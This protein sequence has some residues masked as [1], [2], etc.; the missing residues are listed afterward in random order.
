MGMLVV[1]WVFKKIEFL[2]SKGLNLKFELPSLYIYIYIYMCVCVCVCV[3][4]LL[5]TS[6]SSDM[7]RKKLIV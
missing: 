2:K 3:W 7:R 5:K 4:L 1:Y 6:N